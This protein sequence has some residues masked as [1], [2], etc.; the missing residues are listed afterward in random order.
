MAEIIPNGD[1][2]LPPN[3]T[4]TVVTVG[5]FDGVHRGHRDV[6]EKLVARAN[7]LGIPSVLVTFD[8]HPME[9]VNPAA[10]PLLL[11]TREE[12]L[13]VLAET[14][15]EYLAVVPFTA[16]LSGFSADEF[17]SRVLRRCF[18]MTELLIGYDHGFGRQRAGNAEVLEELGKREGFRVEVIAPVA[19]RG[20]QS[21]S[22]TSIRRAVA[23]GDLG[24]A[25]ESLGR[26]YSV[27]GKVVP[28][29]QRGRTIGFPTLNLGAPPPRKLLPPEGVY[30]VRAQT[31]KGQL[32]GMMNL[33]PRPT[34]GDA[35][36]SL[37][38]HLFD[39]AGDLYGEAVRLDFI[40]RL[41][42]TRKFPSPEALRAQLAT[43]ERNARR[44]LTLY[45]NTDNLKG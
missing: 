9:V 32:G 40:A 6:V 41:R 43:D 20:G 27:S 14:G 35:A 3:V 33:G 7:K 29:D 39:T 21:I 28:G 5:T 25:A 24:R 42:E 16:A 23:G 10:A 18:R 36:T 13:E 8:P 15:L 22:S 38:A 19:S 1:S 45:S 26:P 11:T 37:E 12:K 31:P 30:A 34:F 4:E 2:A 44:A 17:V